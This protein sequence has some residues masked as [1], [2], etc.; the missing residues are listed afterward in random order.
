M[1]EVYSPDSALLDSKVRDIESDA[2]TN[3][4]IGPY[5][6]RNDRQVRETPKS[7]LRTRRKWESEKRRIRA[8][9]RLDPQE[10]RAWQLERVR[11]L[12]DGAF[13]AI[14]F[15]RELYAAVGFE[16]GDIV[17]WSDFEQLPVVN[18]RMIVD[19]GMSPP[20]AAGDARRTVHSARTSGSSGLNLTIYQDNASVDH[21]AVLNMRHCELALGSELRPQDWRYQVYFAAERIT[22]LLGDY[23]YVTL[24]QECPTEL[25]TEHLEQLRPRIVFAFPSYLQRLVERDVALDAFGVEA[26]ITNSERSSPQER[27]KYTRVLR[28]PVVDEYSSEEFSL[29]AYEC[30]QRRYHLV[31]DSAY[32]EVAQP[33]DSGFGHMVGTSLGNAFMPFIRYDQGDVVR[34]APPG[35][36]CGCGSRF[37]TID[38]FRGREDETLRD[39]P[40]RAV[41]S[42]AVL[43]LCDRTLVVQESNVLQYQ[44]V[45]TAPDRVQLRLRLSDPARR[46]ED[47]ALLDAFVRELP[48][49]FLHERVHV[50]VVHVDAFETFASG[51]RR[52]IFAEG[53][54]T[55][56]AGTAPRTAP[57][58]VR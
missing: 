21:R 3:D 32:L 27:E 36:S 35:A 34:L 29:I 1:T 14:P 12:V 58:A 54:W 18:K 17:T 40:G 16:P 53:A 48:S 9:V 4:R 38:A 23:P 25:L 57:E 2:T 11:A 55:R 42:D 52:L 24:A 22:S 50:D 46:G 30:R 49:L 13:T 37:R 45:Q 6:R 51:K 39:G 56:A 26:V 47:N 31:E 5:I 8:R 10:V 7:Q 19:A 28:V 20:T 41:P 43:G 15:Y 44:L 33:D